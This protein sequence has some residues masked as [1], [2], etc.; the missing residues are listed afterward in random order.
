MIRVLFAIALSLLVALGAAWLITLPGSV[1]ISAFGYR[2]RPGLGLAVFAFVLLI[3]VALIVWALLRRLLG[4]PGLI[5]RSSERRRRRRGV[6]ALS[7]GFIAYHAGDAGRARQLAREARARLGDLPAAQLLEARASMALGDLAEAREAYRGLIDNPKTAVAALSGL[8]EQARQQGRTDAALIFARKAA[9]LSPT[10]AWASAA[11]FDDL[12]RRRAW[13][14]ALEMARN[15]PAETR[16]AREAARRRQA[17]LLSAMAREQEA[18]QPSLAIE[19]AREALKIL[20]DFV[21]AT[22]IA[23]RIYSHQGEARKASNLLHR[24]WRSTNHPHVALLYAHVIPGASPVDRLKRMRALIEEP[25]ASLS[26]AATFARAAI[27]AREWSVA[28]NALAKFAS[29]APTQQICLLMAEIEEGQSADHGK[30]REWLSRAVRAPRDPVW[31]ADGVTA[32]DWQ[33]VSPVSGRLD[34][35]EWRVPVAALEARRPAPAIPAGG[36]LPAPKPDEAA[37]AR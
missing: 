16:A 26:V 28:R 15:Q 4:I 27:D 6:E 10:L 9:V 2:M 23:A 7:D 20:P 3:A 22:L 25:G 12:V 11:V 19:H 35:F 18:T 32:E 24:V 17:V 30:A 36:A 31:T 34:A 33:P 1:E 5:G 13:A 14:G 29:S 21:P 8:Y 37:P